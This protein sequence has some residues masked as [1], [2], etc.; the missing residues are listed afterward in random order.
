MN[1]QE[2]LTGGGG[3]LATTNR[4]SPPAHLCL[5]VLATCVWLCLVLATCDFSKV[6]L[7]KGANLNIETELPT[8]AQ[9]GNSAQEVQEGGF[10]V[11]GQLQHHSKLEGSLGYRRLSQSAHPPPTKRKKNK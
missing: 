10:R 9:A 3:R 8:V 5:R 1:N 11:R 4:I 7:F 2:T 6:I